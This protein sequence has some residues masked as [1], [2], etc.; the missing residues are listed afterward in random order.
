MK[1]CTLPDSHRQTHAPSAHRASRQGAFFRALSACASRGRLALLAVAC[2]AALVAPVPARAAASDSDEISLLRRQIELLSKKVETLEKRQVMADADEG[3]DVATTPKVSLD[4][5]GF[6]VTSPAKDFSVKIGAFV[7]ADARVYI[8]GNETKNDGFLMRRVRTPIS[9][10]FYKIFSFNLTPEFAGTQA[11]KLFDGWIQ[12]GLTPEFNIKAGK[13]KTPASLEGPDNRHFIEASFTNQLLPNR[14]LGLEAFGSFADGLI[15]YRLGVFNGAANNDWANVHTGDNDRDF[16]FSGRLTATPFKKQQN[17]L[18]A[19]AFSVGASFG[20][21]TASSPAIK[22]GSQENIPG[23]GSSVDG[24]HLR[25][26][27]AIAWFPGKPYSAIAEY[28]LDRFAR[29]A[30][31]TI[32]NTAWRV[33]GGYVLTGEKA[34]AKGVSPSRPF[35]VENG[36]WG[37]FELVGRVAGLGI[38]DALTSAPSKAFSYGIGLHWYFNDVVQARFGL[39]KTDYSDAPASLDN[40][41]NFFS[42]L[43]LLF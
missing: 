19:L 29:P 9:G 13:F 25:I 34:T 26:A 7:Q 37:A 18:S 32:S 5:K 43:Q 24:D 22:A 20:K 33:S 4:G 40:E 16:T 2:A 23:T 15:D 14:D 31:D 28:A 21:E 17:L 39:E 12:A 1:N 42:R 30:G 35:S 38:D 10:T 41:L 36:A 27:P 3:K 8:K 11:H 6:A